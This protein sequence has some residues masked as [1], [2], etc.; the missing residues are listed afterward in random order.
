MFT[1]ITLIILAVGIGS[2]TAI[3]SV[4]NGV[5]LKTLPYPRSEE[6]VDVRLTSP[7][8]GAPDLFLAPPLYFTF[9][10]Q[11]RTFRD[12][13]LYDPGINS[14]GQLTN[15]VTGVGEPQRVSALAVTANLLTILQVTPFI[16]RSFTLE[17]DSPG[18][19]ETVILTYSFWHS[20]FGGDRSVLG[21]TIRVDGKTRTIIGVLPRSFGFL[22]IAELAMLLPMQWD[23]AKAMR[24]W[25]FVYGSI[26][27]LKLGITLVQANAE[28]G[29][30]LRIA[31]SADDNKTLRIGPNLRSLKQQV[32]GDVDKVLWVLMGGIG[33]VLVIACAN[34]ANLF[35]ARAEGRRQQLAIRVALGASRSRL[36]SELLLES[37]IL[38]VL[39]GLLGLG[40]AYG[41]IRVLIT[42]APPGLPRLNEIGIDGR[43]VL[44]ALAA[45][46]L[47]SLLFGSLPAFKYTGVSAIGLRDSGR[48]MTES[49]KWHHSR[50][51][52]VIVQVA[53]ALV[54]LVSSGLMIRTFV[55]L[56]RVNPG[57]VA[58]SQVQT[59]RVAIPDTQVKE[60]ERV[61]RI[62]E[63]ISH[64]LEAIPS[65]SSV[66][67]SRNLPMDGSGWVESTYL[68]DRTY[69]PGELAPRR[70]LGFFAPGFLKTLG[71][72]LVAGRDFTWND[73]YNKVPVV[74][75]SE[76]LARE[77][78][79]DPS[80]ALGKQ[81]SAGL[82]SD[83]HEIVGIV[84]DVH[85]DGLDK[86]APATV[87][88]PILMAQID[89]DETAGVQ[90]EVAFAIRSPQAGLG[91]LMNAV[92][93][94]VWSVDSSLPVGEVH[95]LDYYYTRS[96]ARTSF[97]LVM[98]AIAGA[99]AL[100]LGIVGLYGTIAYS[101]SQRRR[102][103][104]TRIALG[105][106][107]GEVLQMILSEGLRLALF[108][109]AIGLA[110]ALGLA[111]FLSSLLYGVKPHDPMTLVLVSVLLVA[112]ALIASYIP[113]R[114]AARIDPV[115][116]LRYE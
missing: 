7:G 25:Y 11:N 52:L 83:W 1:A 89:G 46:F 57:F 29:R 106:G 95:T 104:G 107:E 85:Q 21:R 4:L 16:G 70:R 34:L 92:R 41:G 48:S 47:S 8:L 75:I 90:R 54:L 97:T 101:V 108:G 65:V 10:E 44:F 43:V 81:I 24:T 15:V 99:M 64:K 98:L 78:W 91:T 93:R 2:T 80:K 37:L 40:L 66:G 110:A 112:V 18:S 67:I 102:E 79:H 36:A 56:T 71:T 5:L 32:T 58:P 50:R 38:A 13:G 115:V 22:N 109:V 76:N 55:A 62:Q 60:P 72:P 31:I 68:K 96:M 3:F 113:A 14:A 28:V 105:A 27:R 69:A 26:A 45:S 59:F 111:R 94:A 20:R 53:L 6:L 73:I 12:I 88:L 9:H 84:G 39:G 49:L 19:A 86:E 63:E 114:E 23:R 30:M 42:M 100:V 51:L 116:A 74:M 103:I 77:Y 82:P 87:Y 17:D 33:L 61:V 35:L